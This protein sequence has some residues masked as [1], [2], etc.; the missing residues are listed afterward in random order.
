MR[1][2]IREHKKAFNISQVR[3]IGKQLIDAI[4]YLHENKIIHRDIKPE[5][6]LFNKSMDLIKVIDLGV[7]SQIDETNEK[8][9]DVV[10]TMRYMSPEQLGGILSFKS[11]IWAFGCIILEFL[12]GI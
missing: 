4:F 3:E 7:S 8:E 11:D 9:G 5:N 10:G 6:I 2:F 12:T 1:Q